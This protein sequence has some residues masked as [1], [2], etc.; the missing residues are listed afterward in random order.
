MKIQALTLQAGDLNA[1]RAL[2][3]EV[4]GF[5]VLFATVEAVTFQIGHTR[6][7]FQQDGNFQG[8]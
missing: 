5:P 1:Q 7:T 2:Y 8:P 3:A 4:L 6:L